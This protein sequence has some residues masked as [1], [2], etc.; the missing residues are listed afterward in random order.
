MTAIQKYYLYLFLIIFPV[1]GFSQSFENEDIQS[2]SSIKLNVLALIDYTPSV[3]V[4]YQ[5][6]ISQSWGVQYEAGLITH[7]LSPFFNHDSQMNGLRFKSQIKYFIYKNNPHTRAYVGLDFM[8]KYHQFFQERWFGFYDF[9]YMQNVRFKREK[10]VYSAGII[11]GVEPQFKTTPFLF[12]IYCGIGFRYLNIYE[13]GLP[14]DADMN[15]F[16]FDRTAGNYLLPNI[17]FGMRFGYQIPKK[18]S[19]E[20]QFLD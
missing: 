14:K 17:S 15:V 13:T 9:S 12:D 20:K 1:I 5:Y 7:F 3:Q 2:K 19:G 18:N 4:A 16:F 6:D 8:Y 10:E 11:W